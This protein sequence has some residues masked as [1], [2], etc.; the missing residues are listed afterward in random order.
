MKTRIII[1]VIL[2]AIALGFG[3]T[4]LFN[5]SSQQKAQRKELRTQQK[6]ITHDKQQVSDLDTDYKHRFLL[7]QAHSDS[8]QAVLSITKIKLKAANSII[9]TS[10]NKLVYLA[11]KDTAGKTTEEIITDCDSL[12]EQAVAF[13]TEVDSLQALH[14]QRESELEE[15][16]TSKD[17]TIEL[18]HSSYMQ[19][20]AITDEQLDREQALADNLKAAL[21]QQRKQNFRNKLMAVG[22]IITSSLSAM[23]YL[24]PLR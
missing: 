10:K 16:V 24:K 9:A 12:K 15:L 8:L 18:C 1:I 19:L 21:K 22:L 6:Q 5:S 23:L 11:Q 13:A 17:S 20:K 14:E 7:L 4:E 2:C 3:L